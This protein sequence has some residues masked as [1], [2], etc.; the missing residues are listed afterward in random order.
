MLEAIEV[1]KGTVLI[2]T[3]DINF[4]TNWTNKILDFEELQ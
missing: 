1:F 2:T 4:S 3:H